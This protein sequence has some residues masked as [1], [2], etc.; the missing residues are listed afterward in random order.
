MDNAKQQVTLADELTNV[1]DGLHNLFDEIGLARYEREDRE[2][3][4]YA[5]L[6]AA[7]HDQLRLVA[8]SVPSSSE[9]WMRRLTSA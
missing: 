9:P 6:N 3:N 8:E 4:V 1:I 5:A 7:L 2:A